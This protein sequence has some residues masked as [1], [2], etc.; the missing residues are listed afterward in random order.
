MPSVAATGDGHAIIQLHL[1][2]VVLV[3]WK[4]SHVGNTT[5]TSEKK[6]LSRNCQVT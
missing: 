3:G 5:Y 6:V 4:I 2:L 1:M